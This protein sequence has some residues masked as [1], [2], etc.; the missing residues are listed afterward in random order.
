[1]TARLLGRSGCVLSLVDSDKVIWKSVSWSTNA[2]VTIKE[3]PRL[4]SLTR[5]ESF[6]SWVVQDE[7]GRGITILDAKNDP[8]CTHMRVK[9]GLEFYAGVPLILG[10]KHRIGAISI[11]GPASGQISLIDMNI[12]HEMAIWASGELDTI[13]LQK[14]LNDNELMLEGQNKLSTM[15]HTARIGE[16]DL[17]PR[18]LE[19]VIHIN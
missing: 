9:A 17:E 12:L 4:F 8:R 19:K 13:I 3:E 14:S 5:Y 6:C 16:K 18:L 10:G 11:Q 2:I 7:S 1:M 15:A